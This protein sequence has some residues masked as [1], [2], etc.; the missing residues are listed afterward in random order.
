MQ[1]D[2][3]FGKHSFIILARYLNVQED[4]TKASLGESGKFTYHPFL[5][6]ISS[7]KGQMWHLDF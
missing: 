5:K 6:E 1:G 2:L 7:L 4:G 3:K